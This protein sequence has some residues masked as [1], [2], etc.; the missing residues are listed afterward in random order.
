VRFIREQKLALELS[1]QLSDCELLVN[2]IWPLSAGPVFSLAMEV[3]FRVVRPEADGL[4]K[5]EN[6]SWEL[7][8]GLIPPKGQSGPPREVADGVLILASKGYITGQTLNV[9]G[10]W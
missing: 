9:N 10:G 8:Q 5:I 3:C 7:A 6:G 4:R 2:E 1:V